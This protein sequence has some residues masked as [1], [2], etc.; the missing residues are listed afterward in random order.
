MV[1]TGDAEI[2]AVMREL[3]SHGMIR[4]ESRFELSEQA[5]DDG[6]ANPWFYEMQEIGWNYRLPDILCALG[7]TQLGKLDH[8]LARR[9]EIADRYDRLVAPLYPLLRPVPRGNRPHGLHL[10]A[11][12]IDFKALATTRAR[13]MAA[14]RAEGIG[15]QVH[16]IPLHWQPYY[17]RRYGDLRLPSAE[18]YYERCLSI[19]LFPA[20]TDGD[21]DRVVTT[22]KRL[23]LR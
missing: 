4:D 1:T 23:V 5:F 16:Y 10:Y 20:M 14:L 6:V 7:L 15:T 19:P 21:V 17:R 9:R 8:F 22:L 11:V 13:F 3:R 18:S 2:A 12:H